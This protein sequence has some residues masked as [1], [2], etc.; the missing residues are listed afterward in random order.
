M[1]PLDICYTPL[2]LPERPSY[3]LEKFLGWA[4]NIYPQSFKDNA[5]HAEE[6]YQDDYPWDLVFPKFKSEWRDGFREE[7]PDIARYCYEGFNLKSYEIQS[8]VFLLIRGNVKGNS[9]W[10]NDIDETGFRFYLENDDYQTN[11]LL[12]KKTKIPY[13]ERVVLETPE[14]I[15]QL[16]NEETYT[17]KLPSAN[18]PFY[19]NNFRSAH[20]IYVNKPGLRIAGFIT[21]N[22]IFLED[23]KK[24]S[25]EL[26]INSAKKY[27]DYSILY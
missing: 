21:I 8:I 24:R 10:H 18:K 2:D 23:V 19:L 15:S 22:D 12:V 25:A 3:D 16:L 7:F 13:T 11:P 26:I 20:S 14:A 4:K 1:T 6:I 5:K 9:F 27:K 17:C